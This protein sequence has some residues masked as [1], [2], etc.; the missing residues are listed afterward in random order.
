MKKSEGC[1]KPES[2]ETPQYE[3]RN[4]SVGFLRKAVRAA[5]GKPSKRRARKRG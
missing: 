4:H 2:Q 1:G 3:A 5:E